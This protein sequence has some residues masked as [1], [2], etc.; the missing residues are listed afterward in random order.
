MLLPILYDVVCI[1]ILSPRRVC[2]SPNVVHVC[3]PHVITCSIR[4]AP[5]CF[6]RRFLWLGLRFPPFHRHRWF[7]VRY[8]LSN[9]YQS[10]F[11]NALYVLSLFRPPSAFVDIFIAVRCIVVRSLWALVEPSSWAVEV[12]SNSGEVVCSQKNQLKP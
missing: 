7:F 9:Y 8:S 2:I 12:Q 4:F 5:S 3:C 6:V 11:F 1:Y 10:G